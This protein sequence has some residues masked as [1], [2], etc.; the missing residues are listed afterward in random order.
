[1]AENRRRL[2][3][4]SNNIA[5]E[6]TNDSNRFAVPLKAQPGVTS[7]QAA[8]REPAFDHHSQKD[9]AMVVITS[10]P[11][12]EVNIV[13]IDPDQITASHPDN[14]SQPHRKSIQDSVK[15]LYLTKDLPEKPCSSVISF[16][17][18]L[19]LSLAFL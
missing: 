7:S 17:V 1:M 19:T 8:P 13:E 18:S 4:N 15:P 6:P 11:G 9:E 5:I 3:S 2:S 10:S 12:Q 16:P 14:G